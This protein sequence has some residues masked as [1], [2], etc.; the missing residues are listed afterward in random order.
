MSSRP[1]I[2]STTPE[3]GCDST[4]NVISSAVKSYIKSRGECN[5]M[6]TGGNTAKQPY[7]HWAVTKPWDHRNVRYY[8]GD[9]RCVP[10]DNEDSNYGMVV[11]TLFSNGISKD[12]ALNRMEGELT[13]REVAAKNY[14][15][16]LPDSIDVL[17]LSVGIDGYIA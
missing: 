1:N 13:D 15:Q 10:P 8:F 16:M 17:L 2:I 3:G 14:E 12:C 6:L 5:L 11:M 9:E 7:Q 4:T